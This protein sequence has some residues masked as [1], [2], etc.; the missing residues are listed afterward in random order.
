[1]N[2]FS[3]ADFWSLF[4][5]WMFS[6]D[7]FDQ[8]REQGED[9]IKL[10][11]ISAGTVLD[12]CCGPARHSVPL[13]KAGFE[14]TG[15]DIQTLLLEKAKEYAA[16]ESATIEF[17]IE[18]M[19]SFRRMESFDLVLNMFSSFGYFEYP[20][21]DLKVV[22]NVYYSLKHGGQFLID[23]RGKEVHAKG[24]TETI[25]SEMP[26]GDLVFQRTQNNDDWTRAITTWVYVAGHR[27]DSFEV[28]LN[29]YS[30]A[31]MRNLLRQAGFFNVR[32][33]GDLKGSPYD[34]NAN[35]LIVVAEKR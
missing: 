18:D 17:I 29:L 10:S 20:S 21:E 4:Y 1:M 11:G 19:R 13:R 7:S 33:Y 25:S 12:L 31:E 22:E 23:L 5:D 6:A 28:T 15:V 27:A 26:N 35:R 32:L 3:N 24:F 8:A 14:V 30:G 16:K 2:W 34:H 9:I